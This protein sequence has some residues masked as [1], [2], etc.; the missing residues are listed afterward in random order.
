LEDPKLPAAFCPNGRRL[1]QGLDTD[2]S[3]VEKARKHIFSRNLYGTVSVDSYDGHDLPYID[4]LVNLLVCDAPERPTVD[5]IMPVL[6]PNGVAYIKTDGKWDVKVKPR[7]A[8]LDDWTHYLYNAANHTVSHDRV[9]G[10]PKRLQWVAG[11]RW[12]RHHEAMS[13]FQA[14]VSAEG[15]ICVRAP[16]RCGCCETCWSASKAT[17]SFWPRPRRNTG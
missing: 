1:V 10:P 16:S 3:K 4:N 14:L 6:V 9:V 15:R 7:P 12:T 5:E 2:K 8:E 17:A 11:P 13:S